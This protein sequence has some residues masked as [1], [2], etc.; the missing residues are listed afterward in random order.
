MYFSRERSGI[1]GALRTDPKHSLS[2]N[3]KFTTVKHLVEVGQEQKMIRWFARLN[4][5]HKTKTRY[6]KLKVI[7]EC[8]SET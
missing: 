8:N 1:T 4:A 3:S 6:L 5:V 2:Y 7:K